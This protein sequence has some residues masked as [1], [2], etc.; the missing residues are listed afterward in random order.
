MLFRV[1]PQLE[2]CLA[3]YTKRVMPD[4][5]CIMITMTEIGLPVMGHTVNDCIVK[6]T[7]HL[8]CPSNPAIDHMP[9]YVGGASFS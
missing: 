6:K 5:V 2:G 9:R 4:S 1:T 7:T 3:I 8:C